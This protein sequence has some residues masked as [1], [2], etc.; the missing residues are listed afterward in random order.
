[1]GIAIIGSAATQA[2]F[3]A[4]ASARGE[5]HCTECGYG[6][7]V[8]HILPTCPMCRGTAALP[9]RRPSPADGRSRSPTPHA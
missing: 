7:T 4:G 8:H 6:I 2:G 9:S 3:G 5:F 1:M